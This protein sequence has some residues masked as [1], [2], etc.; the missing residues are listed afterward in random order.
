MSVEDRAKWAEQVR[1]DRSFIIG[2][3]LLLAG[4]AAAIAWPSLAHDP[5]ATGS[6]AAL[7]LGAVALIALPWVVLLA[8]RPRLLADIKA[9]RSFWLCGNRI[10][11]A[12]TA[13]CGAIVIA[14]GL[15]GA[16]DAELY[17]S[18]PLAGVLAGAGVYALWRAELGHEFRWD[19]DVER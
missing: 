1:G 12:L 3:W 17:R 7:G 4:V 14:A 15:T 18:A 13:F 5:R 11:A 10:P 6:G 16:L 9:G 19:L 8:G 2:G